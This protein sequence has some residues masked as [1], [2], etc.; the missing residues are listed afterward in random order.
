MANCKKKVIAVN[1]TANRKKHKKTKASRPAD[2]RTCSG[3]MEYSMGI[4]PKKESGSS[5]RIAAAFF[6][7]LRAA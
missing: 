7:F 6:C 4:H 5:G 3:V 2:A 1:F